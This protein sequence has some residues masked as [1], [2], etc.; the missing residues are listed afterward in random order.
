MLAISLHLDNTVESIQHTTIK[1]FS[2]WKDFWKFV[3][4]LNIEETHTLVFSNLTLCTRQENQVHNPKSY[5]GYWIVEAI[6]RA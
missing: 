1:T 5:D 3:S 6:E 4:K 2:Y